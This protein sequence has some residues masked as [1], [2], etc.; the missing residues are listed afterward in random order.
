MRLTAIRT[1]LVALVLAACGERVRPAVPSLDPPNNEY[2]FGAV[3]VLNEVLTPEI[4]V[5]NVG[6]ASM[7]ISDVRLTAGEGPFTLKSFPTEIDRASDD[8]IVVA[9]L[10]T[11]EQD[12]EA[13]LVFGTD[14]VEHP[15]VTVKLKGKGSTRAV[16]GVMP[17]EL[18]FGRVNE[19]ACAIQ[20]FAIENSGTAELKVN[21]LGFT[22][23][24]SDLFTK[25]GSWGVPATVKVGGSITL[26]VK[27][28]ASA[29][30]TM[31]A[32]G[33]IRIAGTDPDKREVVIPLEATVNKAPVPVIAMLGNGA[34]G[35]T[36]TLDGSGSMDPDG[37]TPLVYKWTLRSAPVSS[38]TT[39]AAPDAAMTTMRLDPQLPG[40]YEVQLDVTDSAGAKSCA[41][42]RATVVA[43]P[44]QK[45]LVEMFWDNAKT[46]IDLHVLRTPTSVLGRAPDDCHYAN[47]APDWGMPGT[48]DDPALLR[49]ALTGYGPEIFGYVNPIDTTY[50]IAATFAN[51]HLEAMPSTRVT[52]RVYLFGV[53]KFEQT[54]V[55]ATQG[56]TWNAV[57]VTWP[58]GMVVPVP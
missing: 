19:C 28:C 13:T 10:P 30:M 3:P 39:I 7:V 49:D 58:S 56:S 18:D 17:A 35:Q 9:F 24:T 44:A 11:K 34:P 16:M 42:V 53:V 54:K 1:A 36:V 51:D 32:T 45:L 27:Y 43:S 22:A 37:D 8:K 6:G 12:Y 48:M 41:P 21:E 47:M 26:T 33:G 14:D 55:L 57:D 2:D 52:I 23:G 46:D 25:V 31:P 40:S 5:I 50:R 15:E 29:G 4:P 20:T 38:T